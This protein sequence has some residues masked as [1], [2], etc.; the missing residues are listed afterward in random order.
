MHQ[1][2]L[3]YG[4]TVLRASPERSR[5]LLLIV[6]AVTTGATDA[7]AF[8]RLGEVFASVIT[9]N[10]VLLGVSVAGTRGRAALFAGCAL[11]CYAVGVILAAPRRHE[12]GDAIW[13]RS[14]TVALSLD[15]AL[16]AAFAVG[17]ELVG[18]H[19]SETAQVLL[20]AACATAMGVQ[21]TAVRRL[22]TVSTTYLTSTFIGLL[23]ALARLRWPEEGARS[24]GILAA[25][26][27]GAA[28]ST[29]LILYARRWLPAL[30]LAPV[31]IVVVASLRIFAR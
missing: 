28:G 30:Q 4:A 6:L 20:L 24:T 5:D 17:W 11:A 3:G 14:T 21:S 31:A 23:E 25:A 22:G 10:L 1:T 26:L 19:P 29:L 12:G 18:T 16:L 8:E 2:R 7:A 13:P 9:G 27:A 15:L